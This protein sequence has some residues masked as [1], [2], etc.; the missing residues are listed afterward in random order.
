MQKKCK[1]KNT[2]QKKQRNNANKNKC[3]FHSHF[4]CTCHFCLSQTCIFHLHFFCNCHVCLSQTCICHFC[5]SLSCIYQ[6]HFFALFLHF[7][8]IENIREQAQFDSTILEVWKSV[9]PRS[10]WHS[11]HFLML[12][13]AVFACQAQ[14]FGQSSED[15]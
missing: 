4:F 8:Q 14:C 9:Q 5:L 15:D 2:L 1:G 11:W 7:F 6:S 10:V 12:P 3:I 13:Q